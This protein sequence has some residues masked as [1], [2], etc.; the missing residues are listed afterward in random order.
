MDATPLEIWR[1]WL[2]EH[3]QTVIVPPAVLEEGMAESPWAEAALAFC[4]T[5]D[6]TRV[7]PQ[8]V[9]ALFPTAWRAYVRM[10][11]S[12]HERD[13]P[14]DRPLAYANILEAR[15]AMT[16]YYV[17]LPFAADDDDAARSVA[18]SV[19]QTLAARA[20]S[21]APTSAAARWLKARLEG[22]VRDGFL[23]QYEM[24]VDLA[25]ATPLPEG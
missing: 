18:A 16:G 5:C 24:R 9:L 15:A 11:L 3:T 7:V 1:R 2:A 17:K 12:A 4:E 22:L 21:I 13:E 10:V 6:D 14:H 20:A 23:E 19:F 8:D 25:G